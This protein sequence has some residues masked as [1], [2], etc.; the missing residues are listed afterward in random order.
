M[1][2]RHAFCHNSALENDIFHIYGQKLYYESISKNKY[3]NLNKIIFA[4]FRE[5][6]N[7]RT[8]KNRF[9]YFNFNVKG[10]DN[11]LP[12]TGIGINFE[13]PSLMN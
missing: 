7:I 10:C 11:L 4:E 3:L 5:T 6:S 1:E 13:I 8:V 9:D 2:V 12:P